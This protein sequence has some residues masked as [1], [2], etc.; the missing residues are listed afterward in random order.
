[1]S[2]KPKL[3]IGTRGSPLALA[4]AYE[5]RERLQAAHEDLRGDGMIEIE[6]IKTTGD[7]ILDRPLA[8]IGGKGLFTK[9]IDDAQ[10]DGRVDIAVHSMK[11]VPTWLPDG[12]CL[13]CILPREDV[14]DVFISNKAKTLADLP[15][16]SV[17]GTASLRRQAQIKATY[18]HLKVE[19]FRGNVQ[20]RLRKLEEGV[21][22]ATLLANAGMRRLK[23]EDAITSVIDE[24]VMLPA[25]AQGAIGITCRTNDET[26]LNYLAALNCQ[27]SK[28]R[29][30]AERAL[31][32]VLDGS[33]RTPI[34]ALAVIEGEEIVLKGL[35]AKPD[36]SEVLTNEM[37]GPVNDPDTLG[38]KA[39]QELKER[40]GEDFLCEVTQA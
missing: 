8:E 26:M 1:M 15:E 12:I 23:N 39:G 17:V 37:R 35:L 18:P 9:E 31:L 27:T 11:D 28:T 6:V 24:D 21:V 25:V 3:V 10:L 22:D 14:R 19:T 30:E 40:A 38:T 33:C 20:S 29:I 7:M 13:P 36:G 34:A 32:R 16:G 5:T 2:D 4:Q